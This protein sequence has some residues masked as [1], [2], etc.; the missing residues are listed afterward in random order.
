LNIRVI[1]NSNNFLRIVNYV[2][3]STTEL[4][5]SITDNI[6]S[7][8]TIT[9]PSDITILDDFSIT[10]TNGTYT[11]I[12]LINEINSKLQSN[13][14][15]FNESKIELIA[16]SQTNIVGSNFNHYILDIKL[17]RFTTKIELIVKY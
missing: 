10:L 3:T 6:T 14:N 4:I 9:T 2:S 1:D 16:E 11:R 7:T 8:S 17:N 15:L 12:N 13:T 5:N